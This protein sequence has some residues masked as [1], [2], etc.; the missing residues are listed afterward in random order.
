M[1]R[2]NDNE[3]PRTRAEAKAVGSK[4]YFTGKE[5]VNGHIDKRSTHTGRCFE[6]DRMRKAAERL[7]HPERVAE[8][9]KRLREK[10]ID[11]ARESERIRSK[12]RYAANPAHFRSYLKEWRQKN[13]EKERER[14]RAKYRKAKR[15][16][17][18]AI[19]ESGRRRD[20]KRRSTPKGRLDNAISA[21]VHRGMIKG[22]KAGRRSF[23]LLGYTLSDLMAHLEKNFLPGMSWENY[24]KGGWHI[25][26]IIPRSAF[27]YETPDDIDFRRCWALTN[28]QPLWEADNMIKGNKLDKPFQPSLAL[29][30]NDNL[31][32]AGKKTA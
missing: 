19:R 28:L 6:C 31:P 18:D 12:E 25:D 32:P 9:R 13:A 15:D 17:P 20:E 4:R 23:D 3:L 29:A 21:G 30:D 11:A 22:A 5:C 8:R 26:H 16:N 2:D 1:H 7:E 24:G 10:N 27:N 14:G